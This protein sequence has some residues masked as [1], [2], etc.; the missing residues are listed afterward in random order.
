MGVLLSVHDANRAR[1]ANDNR[2]TRCWRRSSS[3]T[4]STSAAH[5]EDGRPQLSALGRGGRFLLRRAALSRT[6]T[7]T[8]FDVRSLVGLIPLYAVDVFDEARWRSCRPSSPTLTGSSATAATWSDRHVS[9]IGEDGRT[10]A[11]AVDRRPPAAREAAAAPAGI[12]TNSC[13]RGHPQPVEAPRA[14]PFVFDG[15]EVRYEPAEADVKIK[16]GN[17]NWR[18]PVWFPTSYLLI[19]SLVQLRR[20]AWSSVTI[21]A[22]GSA[23]PVTP[24]DDRGEIWP[25][26]MIGLFTRGAGRPPPDLRRRRRSSTTRTGATACCS[27]NTSTGT[28]AP[29][30]ARAT[31]RDGRAWWR[32]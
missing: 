28:T 14:Q 24:R 25:N 3:S 20:G 1:A 23:E 21:D 8:S 18:G 5:E 32:T 13:R 19:Q 2:P 27:T 6:A 29:G 31:R 11:R 15:S 26:R 12:R 9:P 4:S 22:A 7:S 30:W 17:S 16:G 10:R